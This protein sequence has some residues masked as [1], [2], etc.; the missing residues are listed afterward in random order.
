M[1]SRFS[2]F[3]GK[4]LKGRCTEVNNR[5]SP[6]G[7]CLLNADAD[8]INFSEVACFNATLKTRVVSLIFLSVNVGCVPH[9]KREIRD[10]KMKIFRGFI[11]LQLRDQGLPEAG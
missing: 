8:G 11:L 1:K 4:I 10:I 2:N 9:E 5:V 7:D 6:Y 3:V